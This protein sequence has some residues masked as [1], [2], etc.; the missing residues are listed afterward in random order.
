MA[1]YHKPEARTIQELRDIANKLR[2]HS[3][4]ATNASKSGVAN[5]HHL[6]VLYTGFAD[7]SLVGK[8]TL[9]TTIADKTPVM[10][11]AYWFQDGAS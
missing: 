10:S 1:N 7:F 9:S 8:Y 4:N 5:L 6:L 3:I 11:R 2:I